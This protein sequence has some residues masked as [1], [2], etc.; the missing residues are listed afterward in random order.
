MSTTAY[1]MLL[2]LVQKRR[3]IRRFKRDPVSD[4]VIEKIIEVARW[5]PSDFTTQPWVVCGFKG[6]STPAG[7]C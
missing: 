2:Q 5:A 3:N 4:E 1:D 6:E 7:Y